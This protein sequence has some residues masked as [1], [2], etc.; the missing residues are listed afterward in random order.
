MTPERQLTQIYF[1]LLRR[2][3]DAA[4]APSGSRSGPTA[5]PRPTPCTPCSARPST[6][7]GSERCRS[8][9]TA[10]RIGGRRGAEQ[11]QHLVVADLV[12]AVVPVADRREPLRL[13]RAH[14]LVGLAGELDHRLGRRHRHGEHHPGCV[15]GA[16][17]GDRCLGRSIRWR[18]RRRRARPSAPPTASAVAPLGRRE[19]APPPVAPPPPPRGRYA[20]R[21][22]CSAWRTRSSTTRTPPSP[23]RPWPARGGRG[24]PP[25]ARSR[26]RA[27]PAGRWP[28]RRPPPRHPRESEHHRVDEAALGQQGTEPAPGIDAIVVAQLH[29]RRPSACEDVRPGSR[30]GVGRPLR[31]AE[32]PHSASRSCRTLSTRCGGRT[33]KWSNRTE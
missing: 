13:R 9:V 17:H 27:A 18:C 22:T 33:S 26:R 15:R 16:G 30:G 2:L 6:P 21:S 32:R 23:S 24:R 12:E 1:T 7:P 11:R 29:R 31:P 28:P 25:S 8:A 19:P 14:D 20:P 3:P 5:R 10:Q 4:D